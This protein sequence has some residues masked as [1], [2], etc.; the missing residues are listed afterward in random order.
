MCLALQDPVFNAVCCC[1]YL[2]DFSASG[3][4][5]REGTLESHG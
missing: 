5:G 3:K 4:D 1:S 2:Q